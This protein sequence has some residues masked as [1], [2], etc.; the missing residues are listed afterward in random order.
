MGGM[1]DAKVL[2]KI[3]NR[4]IKSQDVEAVKKEIF[5]SD[6]PDMSMGVD[7][8][9]EY[10]DGKK[11]TY[12][13]GSKVYE[14]RGNACEALRKIE[15]S[16]D[17][18]RAKFDAKIIDKM[19][20][21]AR[22]ATNKRKNFKRDEN[23][24]S[25]EG[26]KTTYGSALIIGMNGWVCAPF[27]EAQKITVEKDKELFNKRKLFKQ[28]VKKHL[29]VLKPGHLK[30]GKIRMPFDNDGFKMPSFAKDSGKSTKGKGRSAK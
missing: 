11:C 4:K 19:M 7:L 20:E 13:A 23:K 28:V 21:F 15:Q 10:N 17:V 16:Q 8:M 14:G 24:C 27:K 29:K 22:R 5:F 9:R 12:V 1:S 6:L 2:S 3:T 18:V 26:P 25:Y 30:K